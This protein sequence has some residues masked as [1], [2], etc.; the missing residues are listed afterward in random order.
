MIDDREMFLRLLKTIGKANEVEQYL[1][2]FSSVDQKKFAVVKIGGGLLR[3]ELDVVASSLTLIQRLGL[4]PVVVHGAGSQLNDALDEAGI[5]TERIDGHRVTDAATLE[6][7]RRVFMRENLRLVDALEEMGTRARP[8]TTGVFEAEL[9]EDRRLGFVGEI[10]KVHLEVVSAAIRAGHLPILT[11]LGETPSGQIVNINADVAARELAIAG[12]PHKII[13][14]TPT[15][16]LLDGEGRIIPSINLTED[17]EPLMQQEW[18]N[19]GMRLKLREINA[20]LQKLPASS[21]VSITSAS[22]MPRELFTHRGAGSF[23]H[24]GER[25]VEHDSW[26][27][28]D[29]ERLRELL[30]TCFGKELDAGYFDKKDVQRVFTTETYRATSV[31]TTGG[32]APYLDKFAVTPKARGEGLG[33][34]MWYRMR[35]QLPKLFWRSRAK[36][37]INSWYFRQADGTFRSGDWVVFWYGIEEYDAMRACVEYALSLPESLVAR[38]EA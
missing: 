13:F 3:D 4:Y 14:L 35:Q 23:I 34:S 16:G 31:I 6:V 32:P 18:V 25:V 20:L 21:S 11:C 19:A 15:G 8:I 12:E 38:E 26:E 29:R 17:Y 9:V 10:T 36:N 5:E 37:P 28:I 27:G 24:R 33:A 2:H 30:E 1:Q 22:D 7:A